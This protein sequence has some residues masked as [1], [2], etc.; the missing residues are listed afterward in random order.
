M[1]KLTTLLLL[2]FVAGSMFAQQR[3]FK[4]VKVKGTGTTTLYKQSHALV[5]GNSAYKYWNVLPGVKNDVNKVKKALEDNGFNVILKENLTKIQ[6]IT[7]IDD[8]LTT[9][10]YEKDNRVL[11]YYA[12]HRTHA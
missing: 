3:G 7:I 2:M 4:P 10:G 5:I 1:K 11:I 8:F 6:M 12:G 9:Y